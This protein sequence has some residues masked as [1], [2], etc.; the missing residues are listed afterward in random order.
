ME[1]F[2]K[3]LSPDITLVCKLSKDGIIRYINPEYTMVTGFTEKE[4]IGQPHTV[5]QDP[6]F[7]AIIQKKVWEAINSTDHTYYISKNYTKQNEYFWTVADIH[8][9]VS[10]NKPTAIF[11]R[12]KFLPLKL[13]S[14]VENLFRILYEI[15]THGGGEKVAEK[16]LNGWLEDR[17]VGSIPE[18]IVK[19]FGGKDKLEKYMNAE[20]PL[21]EL[22]KVDPREMDIDEILKTI[23]KKKR[24]RI[25]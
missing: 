15:E 25:W 16:Y 10:E 5:L 2:E 8:S 14:E 24:F 11:I 4:I 9:K 7:P 22:L 13:R 23:K 1:E 21:D 17:N 18:Y 3:G 12:K 6:K 19:Y 20:V